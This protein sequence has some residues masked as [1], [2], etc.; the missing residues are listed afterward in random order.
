MI[1]NIAIFTVGT[2]PE[3]MRLVLEDR[4]GNQKAVLLEETLKLGFFNP[5]NGDIIHVE[6]HDP[7]KTVAHYQV[8]G[9]FFFFFIPLFVF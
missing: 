2:S 6:D 4:Q 1:L 8:C 5:Q 9:D 3:H 7:F